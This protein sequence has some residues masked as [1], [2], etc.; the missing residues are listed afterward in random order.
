MGSWFTKVAS[1]ELRTQMPFTSPFIAVDLYHH[2][3][4]HHQILSTLICDTLLNDLTSCSGFSSLVS[5][6]QI[7]LVSHFS[8]NLFFLYRATYFYL[9]FKISLIHHLLST[10]FPSFL[11]FTSIEFQQNILV[12]LSLFSAVLGTT[13]WRFSPSSPTRSTHQCVFSFQIRTQPTMACSPN[14]AHLLFLYIKFYQDTAM[15]IC[16]CLVYGCFHA[17]TICLH[18]LR[19]Y[20]PQKKTVD[21]LSRKSL[22]QCLFPFFSCCSFKFNKDPKVKKLNQK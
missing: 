6:S 19:W 8:Q 5:P 1:V 20:G 7:G 13:L 11:L 14:L 21:L 17:V 2:L 3:L 4:S 22:F 16:L 18:I 9:H 15:L 10:Q 12:I